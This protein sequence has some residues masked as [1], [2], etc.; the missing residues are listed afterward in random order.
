MTLPAF[1]VPIS[2]APHKASAFV[3]EDPASHALLERI[4]RLAPSDANVLIAG[5]TGSGKELIARMLHARSARATH[6]FVAVNCGALSE[7]LADTE[8]FGHERGAFTGADASRPGWFEAANG[9]TLFLDEIGELPRSIQ[10]KLLRVLQERE[11]VRLGSRSPLPIDVRIIA[12][13]HV[14]LEQAV[15]QGRF[16]E[17]LYYR[18]RVGTIEATPLRERRGDIVPLAEYF[19]TKHGARLSDRPIEIARDA[20]ALLI[21]RPWLG[22]I[23]ELENVIQSALV[24]V[25]DGVLS[26][27]AIRGA[28]LPGLHAGRND[29][30][31]PGGAESLAVFD[32]LDRLAG[33]ADRNDRGTATLEAALIELFERGSSNLY[34][35]IEGAVVAAAYAYCHRNQVQTAK[36]LGLSRNIVRARL[37]KIGAIKGSHRSSLGVGVVENANP[38]EADRIDANDIDAERHDAGRARTGRSE[39]SGGEGIREEAAV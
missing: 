30:S 8:L 17:D 18:L 26:A 23:R 27:D 31:R 29:G 16:R 10:V 14:N 37:T 9:G 5:E 20:Q 34:D 35:H 38:D 3:F 33:L 25:H 13:T 4:A 1:S 36:L 39:A 21:E 32:R 22:N 28:L 24:D 6:K 11:V 19:V 12:A 2:L 7:S 15:A